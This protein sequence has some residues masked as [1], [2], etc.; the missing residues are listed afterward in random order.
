VFQSFSLFENIQMTTIKLNDAK[1]KRYIAIASAFT[2][3]NRNA[4][5]LQDQAVER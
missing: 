4:F 1:S 5:N 3:A 2:A